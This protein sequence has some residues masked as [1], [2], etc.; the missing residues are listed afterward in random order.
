MN[1][2]RPI[3]A[4]SLLAGLAA[5]GSQ[6]SAPSPEPAPVTPPAL[7][8][9]VVA[10]DP[11]VAPAAVAPPQVLESERSWTLVDASDAG[12]KSVVASA[13]I[14]IEV[15]DARVVGY[16]GCNRF[17]APLQRGEGSA[18]TLESPMASKRA[19]GSDAMNL[20]E[21]S[22]FNAL[23]SVQ[24]FELDAER[25]RLHGADGLLL[26]FAPGRPGGADGEA[27]QAEGT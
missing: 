22:F 2:A 6:E 7:S 1:S 19:C 13:G 5:C 17:S 10:A 8:E 3:I 24:R 16:G 12:L 27:S 25:L 20:A 23:P 26:E 14:F 11:G 15:Q 9:P 21:R 18:I 4:L